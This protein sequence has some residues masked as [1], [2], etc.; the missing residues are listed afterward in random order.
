MI[1]SP[2]SRPN[3]VSD[4][5]FDHTSILKLVERKWNLPPLT[6]RDAAATDLIETLDLDSPPVFLVPPKLPQS[7]KVIN[8]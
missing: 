1:V 4:T 7:A 5:T 6:H 2:Y 8:I 3:F